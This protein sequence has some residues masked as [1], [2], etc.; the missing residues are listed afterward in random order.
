MGG[1][2]TGQSRS[3]DDRA[4]DFGFVEC[5]PIGGS[6]FRLFA[7][8]DPRWKPCCYRNHIRTERRDRAES[9]FGI[10]ALAASATRY[11]FPF[12]GGRVS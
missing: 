2:Q 1:I 4:S 8:G 11:R 6:A 7:M 9:N 5:R 12:Q 10:L 3:K